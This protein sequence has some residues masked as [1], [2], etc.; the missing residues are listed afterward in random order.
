MVSA[1]EGHVFHNR[2]THTIKV[3]Q[4]ARRLAEK[5]L[6]SVEAQRRDDD[7]LPAAPLNPDATE[8]AAHAH[9][10]GHPPFGHVAEVELQRLMEHNGYDTFEGNAQSFRIVTKV[11]PAN[12]D[13]GGLDLT[14]ATLNGILKYPWLQTALPAVAKS[15]WAAY[16][17][18]VDDFNFARG[19]SDPCAV[20][21]EKS[22]EA[23][24][25]GWADDITYAVHDLEDLFR[26][27][28]IPAERLHRDQ[29]VRDDFAD[30]VQRRWV[31]QQRDADPA[32]IGA[33]LRAFPTFFGIADP[34]DGGREQ[35]IRLRLFTST[36]ISRYVKATTM[37]YEEG[38]WRV[39]IEPGARLEVDVLKL[40][41]WRYVI[42]RPA[43]AGQQHGQK[44]VIRDLFEIFGNAADSADK[45]ADATIL[46]TRTRADLQALKDSGTSAPALRARIVVDG[47]CSMTETRCCGCTA[48]Y[49]APPWARCLT[50]SC[51]RAGPARP[52]R[53]ASLGRC[54]PLLRVRYSWSAA[55]GPLLR[56]RGPTPARRQI[57]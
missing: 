56:R 4:V 52:H 36:L 24:V 6:A 27:G 37:K 39:R 47:L 40:L 11:A 44:R 42:E 26:A 53:C 14:R 48:A 50:P 28:L 12:L 13:Y 29:A 22:L 33:A 1:L 43:L 17:T 38:A 23:E 55:P 8:A 16:D 30:W 41:T 25:M 57:V 15:K 32:E 21:T 46:P 3:A 7:S 18:E 31:A 20:G 9:D 19:G 51:D 2:L 45:S 10:I 49:E 54:P 35:R 5:L 34:Y